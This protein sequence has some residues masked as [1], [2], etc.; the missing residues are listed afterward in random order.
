MENPIENWIMEDSVIA[1][2]L[3]SIEQCSLNDADAAEKAFYQIGNYLKLPLLPADIT[4]EDYDSYEDL[5]LEPHAVLIELALIN[6]MFSD[7]NIKE[8]VVLA[9]YNVYN[10]CYTAFE[11]AAVIHFGDESKIP[12]EYFI[13]F[14]GN[15]VDARLSFSLPTGQTWVEAGAKL[16]VKV[17]K[18]Y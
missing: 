8:N 13:Y 10:K 1:D 6:Y 5:N 15:S 14:F 3:S 4:E 11:E 16:A 7:E 9:I 18:R 2:I 12:E 17:I